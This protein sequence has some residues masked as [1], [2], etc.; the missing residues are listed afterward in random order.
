MVLENEFS[1]AALDQQKSNNPLVSRAAI[2]LHA[3]PTQATSSIE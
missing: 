3:A 2:R 1:E